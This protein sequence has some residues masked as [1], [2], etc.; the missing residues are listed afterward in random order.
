MSFFGYSATK[1]VHIRVSK[2]P[3]RVELFRVEP[4]WLREGEDAEIAWR[5]IGATVVRI[6]PLVGNVPSEGRLKLKPLNSTT[7]TLIAESPFGVQSRANAVVSMVRQ[8]KLSDHLTPLLVK[9]GT[10]LGD[11]SRFGTKK[12]VR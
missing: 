9:L 6:A 11:L 1:E 12:S 10:P 2:N 8:T 7:L 5:V 3:P 4:A